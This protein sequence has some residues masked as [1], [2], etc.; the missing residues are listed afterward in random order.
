MSERISVHADPL[1]D[2]YH[3]TIAPHILVVEQFWPRTGERH[4]TLKSYN[5]ITKKYYS[6]NPIIQFENVAADN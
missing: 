6:Q 3:H 1:T 5:A 2:V 4:F